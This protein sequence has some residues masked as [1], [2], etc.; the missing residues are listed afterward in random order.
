MSWKS[1]P[2]S[3]AQPVGH[4]RKR[5][6]DLAG[7]TRTLDFRNSLIFMTSNI[8]AH[9][10]RR[11]RQRFAHGWRRCCVVLCGTKRQCWR[12]LCT[13]ISSRSFLTVSTAS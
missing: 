3:G 4:P 13:G 10:A 12:T 7:G 6:T 11:H 2:G 1:Q 5:P 8:G 9:Q